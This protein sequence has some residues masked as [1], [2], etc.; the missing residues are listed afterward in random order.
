M[1]IT[2]ILCDSMNEELSSY[3]LDTLFQ[4]YILGVS[5]N[6]VTCDAGGRLLDGK[7]ILWEIHHHDGKFTINLPPSW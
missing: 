3:S 2:M 7:K 1:V 5:Q 4:L 6:F